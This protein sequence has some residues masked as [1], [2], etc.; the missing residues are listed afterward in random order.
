MQLQGN[1]LTICALAIQKRIDKTIIILL[2]CLLGDS[3][4]NTRQAAERERMAEAG[5]RGEGVGGGRRGRG[6]ATVACPDR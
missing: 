3:R 2:S 1:F 5:G 4:Q 6:G